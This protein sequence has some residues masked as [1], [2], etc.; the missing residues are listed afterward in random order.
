M[1]VLL[2]QGFCPCAVT[3]IQR[4]F[5]KFRDVTTH[6]GSGTDFH[7]LLGRRCSIINV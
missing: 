6:S 5:P 4:L 1:G 7:T 3:D 2:L